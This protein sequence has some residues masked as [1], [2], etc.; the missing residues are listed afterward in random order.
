M[1]SR[2]SIAANS[3]ILA[4]LETLTRKTDDELMEELKDANERALH[5]DAVEINESSN[6]LE[7]MYLKLARFC[8]EVAYGKFQ[9]YFNTLMV[10]TIVVGGIAVGINLD[11][12]AERY[13]HLLNA[14]TGLDNT[15]FA[16]FLLEFVVKVVAEGKSPQNYVLDPENS[17]WNIF[18]MLI[19]IVCV[20]PV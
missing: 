18:D 14:Y 6:N 9:N 17:S 12:P 20:S 5:E 19:L 16:I 3:V 13:P 1:F 4:N 15:I 10:S 2:A 8:R 11:Y 7:K